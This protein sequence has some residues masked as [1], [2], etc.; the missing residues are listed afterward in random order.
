MVIVENDKNAVIVDFDSQLREIRPFLDKH[1]DKEIKEAI[2]GENFCDLLSLPVEVRNWLSNHRDIWTD[3]WWYVEIRSEIDLEDYPCVHLGYAASSKANHVVD[4]HLGIF[5][6]RTG[7]ERQNSIV[8][9]FCPWCA[10]RLK[11]GI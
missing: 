2:S 7:G 4:Q 10:R 9:E 6:I 8:I 11:V 5:A 1:T 3:I